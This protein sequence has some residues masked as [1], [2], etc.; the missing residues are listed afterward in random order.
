MSSNKDVDIKERLIARNKRNRSVPIWVVMKTNRKFRTNT[1]RYHWR[2][3]H[4]GRD[5]KYSMKKQ[6]RGE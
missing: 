4:I 3:A 1:K 2:S 6:G 5:V